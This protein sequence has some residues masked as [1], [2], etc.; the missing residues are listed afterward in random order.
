M[1]K[2][3]ASDSASASVSTSPRPLPPLLQAPDPA[4]ALTEITKAL[5]QARRGLRQAR[6]HKASVLKQLSLAEI[7]EREARESLVNVERRLYA[8][9]GETPPLTEPISHDWRA[10]SWD[11]V[12]CP[13]CKHTFLPSQPGGKPRG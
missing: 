6:E 9:L 2:T 8:L 5:S 11:E 10:V 12:W 7:S 13:R 1:S 4:A 3:S